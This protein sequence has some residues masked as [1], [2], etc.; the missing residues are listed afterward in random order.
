MT[1]PRQKTTLSYEQQKVS[2]VSDDATNSYRRKANTVYDTVFI[3]LKI[4]YVLG[5]NGGST[6]GWILGESNVTIE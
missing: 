5:G 3:L 1:D 6:S 2:D 4:D